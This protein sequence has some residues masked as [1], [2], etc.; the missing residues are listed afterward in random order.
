MT[1]ISKIVCVVT[2][3]F[4]CFL[5]VIGNISDSAANYS[6]V[7]KA[8]SMND[9]IP[10][11]SIGYRAIT[12][13]ILQGLAFAIIVVCESLSGIFCAYGAWILFRARKAPAIAFNQAK[14]WATVGLTCGF[15]TWQVLFMSIGGEWFGLWMSPVLSG[16]TS[17]AFHIFM[18]ILVVLVYLT[19]KDE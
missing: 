4:Y 12:N 19:I 8:L 7:V 3:A 14:K 11:S 13:P 5:V 16:A 6:H 17:S 2:V 15:F 9:I 18:M 1:R 10:G